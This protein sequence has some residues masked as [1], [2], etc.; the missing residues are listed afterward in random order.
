MFAYAQTLENPLQADGITQFLEG[1]FGGIMYLALPVI[2]LVLV[3]IGFMFVVARGNRNG[4]TDATKYFG[5]AIVA[6]AL[7]LGSYA[8]AVMAYNTVV[9]GILGW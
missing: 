6:T 8:F 1:V 9:K 2:G 7:I 5:A 3:Y 4:I